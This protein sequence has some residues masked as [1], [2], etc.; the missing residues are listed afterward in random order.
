MAITLTKDETTELGSLA[1]TLEDRRLAGI[2]TVE[3]QGKAAL[4]VEP[5]EK[6]PVETIEG[7]DLV[8]MLKTM[9]VILRR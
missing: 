3:G 5:I 8:D 6:E 2:L 9:M 1:L 7:I 4:V